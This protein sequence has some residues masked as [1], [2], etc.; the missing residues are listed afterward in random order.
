ME[1]TLRAMLLSFVALGLN[2][3]VSSFSTKSF[4]PG[5]SPLSV[6]FA[7]FNHDGKLDI[8]VLN[9]GGAN[10]NNVSVL[11]GDGAGN[12]GTPISTPT[13]VSSAKI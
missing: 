1:Y 3:Q 7:D 9:G 10:D 4:L 5:S 6:H 11:L 13:G 8:V 2:A 12:F